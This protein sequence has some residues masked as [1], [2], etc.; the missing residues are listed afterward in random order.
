[1]ATPLARGEDRGERDMRHGGRQPGGASG[2]DD[3]ESVQSCEERLM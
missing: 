1:M 2:H 3:E